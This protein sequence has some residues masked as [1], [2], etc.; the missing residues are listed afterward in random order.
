MLGAVQ[1]GS[2]M[3]GSALV[4]LLANG[5]PKPMGL[6]MALAGVGCLSSALWVR[7]FIK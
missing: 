1:Y 6:V 4:G 5:T 3:I 7:K 2:G